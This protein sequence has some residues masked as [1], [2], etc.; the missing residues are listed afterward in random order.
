MV[1]KNIFSQEESQEEIA[2]ENLTPTQDIL[3]ENREVSLNRL[4]YLG[5]SEDTILNAKINTGSV[6]DVWGEVNGH[7][8]K[9]PIV[10]F[11]WTETKWPVEVDGNIVEDKEKALK[12]AKM[13]TQLK[14]IHRKTSERELESIKIEQDQGAKKMQE[15]EQAK[16]IDEAISDIFK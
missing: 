4:K 8:I 14:I 7:S 1:E 13:M 16:G 3:S 5:L 10:D 2:K 9:A 15:Q 12:L 6:T 11:D